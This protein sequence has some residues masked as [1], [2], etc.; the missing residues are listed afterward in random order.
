[1][2]RVPASGGGLAVSPP[3]KLLD[4]KKARK[5]DYTDGETAPILHR[6]EKR[7]THNNIHPV[8]HR[9]WQESPTNTAI[10]RNNTAR[11]LPL[12]PRTC[13]RYSHF[14]HLLTNNTLIYFSQ[15][16]EETSKL[17]TKSIQERASFCPSFLDQSA[18][19]LSLEWKH[20]Q[21]KQASKQTSK[22]HHGSLSSTH[23]G[24]AKDATKF[25]FCE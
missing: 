18:P 5:M 14:L 21:F 23:G 8:E 24:T 13:A 4:E 11:S 3:A 19:Y 20:L 7:R 2:T 25:F 15:Q 12:R 10:E 22:N 9:T 6:I 17:N 1:M 16:Q